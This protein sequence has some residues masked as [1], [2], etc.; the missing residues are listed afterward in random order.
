M[1]TRFYVI[2]VVHPIGNASSCTLF[3]RWGRVGENGQQQQKV[4]CLACS[5]GQEYSR[6]CVQGPFPPS[7]A[8]SEF[9]KQFKAKAATDW[10]KRHNMVAKKGK[11]TW[12]GMSS[13][14]EHI[15]VR[16][17][18]TRLIE[19]SFEDDEKDDDKGESSKDKGK[20]K[21]KEEPIPPS[22]LAPELQELC[23]IIFSTKYGI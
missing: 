5:S 17:D 22:Q 3:T 2:Q 13:T 1:T 20:E 15:H 6:I 16:A 18:L 21:E 7:V 23:R 10:E 14:H 4:R 9:K 8:V 11:Y 19:R 12:I